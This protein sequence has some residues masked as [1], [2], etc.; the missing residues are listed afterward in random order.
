[1]SFIS[2]NNSCKPFLDIL[3]LALSITE[4]I[5]SIPSFFS[6]HFPLFISLNNLGVNSL[7]I[8]I[9]FPLLFILFSLFFSESL[10]FFLIIRSFILLFEI[11]TS[12][13]LL[14]FILSISFS[15]N[16][17]VDS[18]MPEIN[19][20]KSGPINEYNKAIISIAIDLI[21]GLI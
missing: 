21:C 11:F 6:I 7:L 18:F 20:F 4:L 14:N 1:M 3:L 15:T 10:L 13:F 16:F 8:S 19:C 9:L 5:Y 17:I 2:S 12:L